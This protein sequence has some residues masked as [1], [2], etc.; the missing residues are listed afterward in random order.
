M[1]LPILLMLG[2]PDTESANDVT[3]QIPLTFQGVTARVDLGT[4]GNVNQCVSTKIGEMI[5]EFPICDLFGRSETLALMFGQARKGRQ[6]LHVRAAL[7]LSG[8]K[9]FG[10][11]GFPT[12]AKPFNF[13]DFSFEVDANGVGRNCTTVTNNLDPRFDGFC[14]AIF[15]SERN[16]FL[17]SPQDQFPVAMTFRVD[18]FAE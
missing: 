1:I 12:G 7:G 16:F 3:S 17:V 2:Q 13:L 5:E 4:D 18:A 15:Q 9:E 14:A 10:S 8:D 11:A 6:I